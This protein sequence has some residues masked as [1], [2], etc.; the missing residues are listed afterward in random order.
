MH[1]TVAARGL[2]RERADGQTL[3]GILKQSAAILTQV[4]A[5]VVIAATVDSE[6]EADRLYFAIASTHHS[7]P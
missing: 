2:I 7:P 3:L 5:R 4:S 6:H 1:R